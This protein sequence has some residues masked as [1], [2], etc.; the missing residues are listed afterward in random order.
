M[1]LEMMVIDDIYFE[2]GK[3]FYLIFSFDFFYIN[4]FYISPP[5]AERY[6]STVNTIPAINL[7]SC[8]TSDYETRLSYPHYM[9]NIFFHIMRVIHY[10][11]NI[12]STI[13]FILVKIISSYLMYVPFNIW[14]SFPSPR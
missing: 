9:K 8:E 11:R 14:L 2:T 6:L 1:V 7:V 4:F 13:Y 10:M 12:F 3:V 5:I